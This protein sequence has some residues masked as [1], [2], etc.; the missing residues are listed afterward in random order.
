MNNPLLY[1]FIISTY[2]TFSI[3]GY[4]YQQLPGSNME[5]PEYDIRV[6]WEK[7][8]VICG[9]TAYG[10]GPSCQIS[11]IATSPYVPESQPVTREGLLP[12]SKVVPMNS[13]SKQLRVNELR[14]GGAPNGVQSAWGGGEYTLLYSPNFQETNHLL[15]PP[16]KFCP[17][18]FTC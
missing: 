5:Q 14:G 8:G 7:F 6:I 4:M 11:L 15:V 10:P 9:A 3:P 13:F 2:L 12:G 16:E 1:S 18:F 17:T